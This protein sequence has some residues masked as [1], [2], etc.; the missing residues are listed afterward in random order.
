MLIY[1]G[2]YGRT[3]VFALLGR[4][5]VCPYIAFGSVASLDFEV[6]GA[7]LYLIIFSANGL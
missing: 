3:Y 6:F 7:C 5:H 2:M 1:L 4:H